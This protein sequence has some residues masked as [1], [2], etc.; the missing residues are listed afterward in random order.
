MKTP[1]NRQRNVAAVAA[2]RAFPKLWL[3]TLA[4][5][6]LI[7][8]I[9]NL[10]LPI[11][12]D[13]AMFHLAWLDEFHQLQK[14]G[15]AYPRWLSLAY[16]SFGSP[17]F[18]FYP[19][20]PYFIGSAIQ[21]V[22]TIGLSALYQV[23]GLIA[24][25]LSG[26]SCYY[27]LRTI[28]IAR[29]AALAAAI[30]YCIAPYR[31]VDMYAR[32]ALGEHF[33]FAFLPL[34]LASVEIALRALNRS[35][36]S[37]AIVIGAIGW[38]G[39]LLVNIP[40][41]VMFVLAFAVYALVRGRAQF[42]R[43][44]VPIAGALLGAL[45]SSLYLIPVFE[46]RDH[47]QTNHIFDI[48]SQEQKWSY[49]LIE[50]FQA[51]LTSARIL[52]AVTFLV[53]VVSLIALIATLRR[54][55]EADATSG[56]LSGATALIAIALFF[57]L[58]VISAMVYEISPI[59]LIKYSWRWNVVMTLGLSCA[60]AMV[61]TD[62]ASWPSYALLGGVLVCTIVTGVSFGREFAIHRSPDVLKE[63]YMDAPEYVPKFAPKNYFEVTAFARVN[64]LAPGVIHNGAAGAVSLTSRSPEQI[65]YT[66]S[67]TKKVLAVFHQFYWPQW[68][69]WRDAT[70]IPLGYDE[71][72]RAV[73]ELEPGRYEAELRL[74]RTNGQM[75]G[76][77]LS[78]AGFLILLGLVAYSRRET[79]P[80]VS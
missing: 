18:Y 8:T 36:I 17:T 20:L 6:A 45:I 34:I 35:E 3:W 29:S 78:L 24:T 37:R 42:N 26:W 75:V 21:F 2:E 32:S 43:L 48:G 54:R 47:I 55:S 16:G 70:L 14:Q 10:T 80:R 73:S 4:I 67:S 63:F 33:S 52:N 25:V 59:D 51:Q 46:L 40:A 38:A 5:A 22:S 39:V 56:L 23:L 50:F 62:R 30:F 69:L 71:Y 49:I 53:G 60:L 9:Q 12:G 74:E 61:N 28:N 7:Q 44:A 66:V 68:K 1:V 11:V 19:P 58:P 72:G 57:Q 13:D 64:K 41:T 65:S 79:R 15:V 31:F 27:F 77:W 76:A